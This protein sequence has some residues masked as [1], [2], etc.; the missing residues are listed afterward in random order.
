[1]S[2]LGKSMT[3]IDQPKQP[4]IGSLRYFE[5]VLGEV[6]EQSFPARY[7]QHLEFNLDRCEQYWQAKPETAPGSARPLLDE[8]GRLAAGRRPPAHLRGD[9]EARRDDDA[10]S[11]AE[12]A[13]RTHLTPEKSRVHPISHPIRLRSN[14]GRIRGGPTDYCET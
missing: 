1:M 4:L 8:A 9:S 2:Y 11:P 12:S 5:G 10:P 14:A 3:L 13:Q 7:W 6:R